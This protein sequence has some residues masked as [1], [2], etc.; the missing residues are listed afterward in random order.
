MVDVRVYGVAPHWY[1]RPFMSWLIIFPHHKI[2]IFGLIFFFLIVFYQP[3]IYRK[4]EIE[5]L[6]KR[7]SPFLDYYLDKNAVYISE[8]QNVENNLYTQLTCLLFMHACLYTT[9]FLPYARFYNRIHSNF[10]SLM[11][12]MYV[13]SYLAFPFL[14]KPY[15]LEQ[16]RLNISTKT[17]KLKTFFNKDNDKKK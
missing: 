1:F 3:I 9:S 8:Y 4:K 14:R 6:Q 17:T 12:F 10:V 7:G 16:I 5:D 11:S 13:F 15:T 2:S